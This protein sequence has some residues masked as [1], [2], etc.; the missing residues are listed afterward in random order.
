VLWSH[1]GDE[2]AVR[3]VWLVALLIT[4]G[5]DESSMPSDAPKSIDAAV[6]VNAGDCP[7]FSNYD[8]PSTH[9]CRSMGTMVSCIAGARGTGAPGMVCTGEQDCASALCV[10]AMTGMRC[11]DLCRT[12]DTCPAELPRCIPLGSEGI[13]AREPP[14]Q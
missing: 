5:G 9:A 7:C 12:A 1:A 3:F 11:S 13:C 4:C 10:E 14:S 2:A 8:C 6:C